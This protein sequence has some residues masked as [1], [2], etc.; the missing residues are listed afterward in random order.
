MA[1]ITN[2]FGTG[3]VGKLGTT[4]FYQYRG[5]NCMRSMPVRRST[6]CSP[7][8]AQNKLRFMAMQKFALQFKYVVIPQIWNQACKSLSGHQLFMKTNK[9]AFDAQGNIPDP[10]AVQLAVGKLHLPM[11]LEVKPVQVGSTRMNVSWVPDYGGGDLA[12]WDELLV[13]ASGDGEYSAIQST[14]I[15][16]G[17]MAGSFELPELKTPVTHLYLFFGSL[18]KRHY[19]ES[20]CY[21]VKG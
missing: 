20:C 21:E 5:K 2:I 18:D 12:W 8:Q 13:I 11:G 16:R 19:S 17:E 7:L 1:R 3:I 6:T 10:K 4:V 15:R 9:A 14:A